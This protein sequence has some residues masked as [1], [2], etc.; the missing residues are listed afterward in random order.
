MGDPP[1]AQYLGVGCRDIEGPED[2]GSGA[3]RIRQELGREDGAAAVEFAL[4][5]GVLAML[6]FGMLQ[7]GLTFF[8]LQNLRAADREGARLGAVAA[9]PDAIRSRIADAS[10][11]AISQSEAT[12]TSFIVVQYSD[13]GTSGWTTKTDIT[14]PACSSSA[15]VTTDAAVRT[16]IFVASAPPHLKNLFTV[17]IPLL[18]TITMTPVIDAQFRCEGVAAT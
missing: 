4:I 8:E 1:V 18:P 9:T 7:F 14:K 13:N 10:G 12:N 2:E 11:G 17:N 3:M 6:I 15:A 5:V 16:Q